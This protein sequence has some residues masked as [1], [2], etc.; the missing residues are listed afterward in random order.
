MTTD[1]QFTAFS[2][3][4]GDVAFQ[5]AGAQRPGAQYLVGVEVRGQNT[6]V[7]GHCD[8]DPIDDPIFDDSVAKI[9]GAFG[10]GP[11]GCTGWQPN[12]PREKGCAVKAH[13]DPGSGELD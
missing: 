5:T 10:D 6:G 1:T 3:S 4:Q 9:D 13:S 7:I 8:S 11:R 2:S 12:I